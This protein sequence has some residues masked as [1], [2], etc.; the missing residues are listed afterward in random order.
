MI[1]RLIQY[2]KETR[3]E[4]KKVNWPSRQETIRFTVIVVVF[5]AA[6]S[7]FLGGFDA[8]FGFILSRFLL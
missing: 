1:A 7:L 6:V 5:S 2:L 3:Q 8:L 4:L